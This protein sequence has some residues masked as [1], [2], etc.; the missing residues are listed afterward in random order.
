MGK[1][2]GDIIPLAIGVAISPVPIVAVILMLGTPRARSN[3]LMFLVGWVAGVV[4]VGTVI[5]IIADAIGISK[6]DPAK[7]TYAFK[8]L[9]GAVLLLG[10]FRRWRKRPKA[11]DEP[12]LPKWMAE[13][14]G[15]TWP[16]SLGFGAALA[17]LNPKNIAL[18]V[19]AAAS[20]SES[21][22]AAGQ[23]VAVYAIFTAITAIGVVL[24]IIVYFAM[25]SRAGKVLDEWK[26][27]LAVNNA[28]VMIV[29]F[30]VFGA[31][32]IGKGIAGLT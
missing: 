13:I 32:L 15:F 18:I 30:L 27:W 24:P 17:G 23:Q 11:G 25:Q 9:L 4:I 26:T 5:L 20:I 12:K 16:K 21:A 31:I 14:D 1:V 7:A 29:L 3:G 8:I 28:T 19:A 6:G 10:A 2:I 22:I